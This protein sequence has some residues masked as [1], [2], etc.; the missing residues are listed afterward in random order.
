LP[1]STPSILLER[2]AGSF[3][4]ISSGFPQTAPLGDCVSTTALAIHGPKQEIIVA[5]CAVLA[6]PRQKTGRDMGVAGSKAGVALSV[7]RPLRPRRRGE[8]SSSYRCR[9]TKPEFGRIRKPASASPP[10][11][12]PPQRARPPTRAAPSR[13]LGITRRDDRP[14]LRSPLANPHSPH[15][16]HP[17]HTRPRCAFNTPLPASDPR[18]SAPSVFIRPIGVPFP[19][20]L[21]FTIHLIFLTSSI[22]HH[23]SNIPP[24]HQRLS[25]FIS[26]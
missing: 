22:S 10:P 14:K 18:K 6:R 1:G 21:Q 7:R 3:T 23:T 16:P 25:A 5:S 11:A 19:A 8:Q 17:H 26:G 12:Q 15:R 4:S 24:S 2:N 20:P 9:P 13:P